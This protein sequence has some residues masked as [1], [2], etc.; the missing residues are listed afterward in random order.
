LFDERANVRKIPNSYDTGVSKWT[1]TGSDFDSFFKKADRNGGEQTGAI[2]DDA[3]VSADSR[4][5]SIQPDP[6]LPAWSRPKVASQDARVANS[7]K[8]YLPQRQ[9][10]GGKLQSAARDIPDTAAAA[11][12]AKPQSDPAR[13][14]AATP[15][16]S[17]AEDHAQEHSA[18][19]SGQQRREVQGSAARNSA[20][21][22]ATEG[23][24]TNTVDDQ[25]TDSPEEKVAAS[26][27]RDPIKNRGVKKDYRLTMQQDEA[28]PKNDQ[29]DASTDVRTAAAGQGETRQ[30]QWQ[31]SP[32]QIAMALINDALSTPTFAANS[33]VR[34]E[35]PAQPPLGVPAAANDKHVAT[36][37]PAMTAIAPA[38]TAVAS[39]MTAEDTASVNDPGVSG[40]VVDLKGQG[41]SLLAGRVKQL[42]AERVTLPSFG[43]AVPTVPTNALRGSR[44]STPLSQSIDAQKQF[45][46]SASPADGAAKIFKSLT[47]ATVGLTTPDIQEAA[48]IDVSSDLKNALA[49]NTEP[50]A[51]AAVPDATAE[52]ASQT[53]DPPSAGPQPGS[54]PAEPVI[55]VG[56]GFRLSVLVQAATQ[57][58][59]KEVLPRGSSSAMVA[60]PVS[61]APEVDVTAS[62]VT[63]T[64]P[65]TEVLTN[66]TSVTVNFVEPANVFRPPVS[67]D[68][69]VLELS[70][71]KHEAAKGPVAPG[72]A[73]SFSAL[74]ADSGSSPKAASYENSAVPAVSAGKANPDGTGF[75][76]VIRGSTIQPQPTLRANAVRIS[77]DTNSDLQSRAGTSSNNMGNRDDAQSGGQHRETTPSPQT[78]LRASTVSQGFESLA[79]NTNSADQPAAQVQSGRDDLSNLQIPIDGATNSGSSAKDV[80]SDRLSKAPADRESSAPQTWSFSSSLPTAIASSEGAVSGGLGSTTSSALNQT[81][82]TTSHAPG[83]PQSGNADGNGVAA[84]RLADPIAEPAA[85][86]AT[87]NKGLTLRID[88]PDQSSV[89]VHVTG[90]P[91]QVRVAVRTG[92]AGLSTALR[93]DLGTLVDSLARSGFHAQSE[94]KDQTGTLHSSVSGNSGPEGAG[95]ELAAALSSSGQ[96]DSGDHHNREG[97]RDGSN[98]QGQGGQYP[99]GQGSHS[100]RGRGDEP[101][102]GS[103]S[104]FGG[105]PQQQRRQQMMAR[106]LA[107]MKAQSQSFEPDNSRPDGSVR[108]TTVPL[109]QTATQYT[110]SL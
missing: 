110:Q 56:D 21:S 89:D 6:H 97:N 82:S 74:P 36:V 100:G 87:A 47:T 40:K 53:V 52:A 49:A 27:G 17:N 80:S 55:R 71:A 68:A 44:M 12:K 38:M 4:T 83:S 77:V 25:S 35:T 86:V 101:G 59:S 107:S 10:G 43:D 41:A 58:A 9:S 70:S 7:P 88:G 14:T 96:T 84:S 29:P 69:F 28:D 60:Q 90:R 11:A 75:A 103:N 106:W 61:G 95:R 23:N 13:E 64:R 1:N 109:S 19:A 98:G 105:S 22:Q 20:E 15:D 45:P 8:T 92:D 73:Y 85:R 91:G 54:A 94:A 2:R 66:A 67:T 76:P 31:A 39:A 62:T 79:L 50:P 32:S 78:V 30:E 48:A 37:P 108:T 3:P 51:S 65:S 102:T 57:G 93:Q 99:G 26:E 33:G 72:S 46:I 16:D 18:A 81:N 104:S 5:N 34:P 63:D 24:D 42:G